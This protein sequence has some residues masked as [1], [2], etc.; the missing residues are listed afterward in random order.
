MK[1]CVHVNVDKG[2]IQP[3]HSHVSS[4]LGVVLFGFLWLTDLKVRTT[5]KLC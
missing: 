3:D 1:L 5:V 4:E 2:S